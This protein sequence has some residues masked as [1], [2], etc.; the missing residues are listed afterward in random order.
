MVGAYEWIYL[1]ASLLV[2]GIV[3]FLGCRK[4]GWKETLAFRMVIGSYLLI[5]VPTFLNTMLGSGLTRN[6]DLLLFLLFHVL[7][8]WGGLRAMLRRNTR[9]RKLALVGWGLLLIL[10][11]VGICCE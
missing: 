9:H 8:L 5:L 4:P 10:A 6:A 11:V 1:A 3:L 7:W 2:P